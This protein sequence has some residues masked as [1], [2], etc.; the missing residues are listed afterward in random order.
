MSNL[1]DNAGRYG[2]EATPG[3]AVTDSLQAMIA[4]TFK[5]SGGSGPK[6]TASGGVHADQ[7]PR[8]NVAEYA[9]ATLSLASPSLYNHLAPFRAAICGQPSTYSSGL[10]STYAAGFSTAASDITAVATGNQLEKGAGT[11][12]AFPTLAV[13]QVTGFAGGAG[14]NPASFAALVKVAPGSS[15]NLQFLWPTLVDETPLGSVTVEY[16]SHLRMG[17]TLQTF[18]FEIFNPVVSYGNQYST[19]GVKTWTHTMDIKTAEIAESFD[20]VCGA[21]PVPITVAAT[22]TTT[23]APGVFIHNSNVHFGDKTH[24]SYGGM[25]RYNGT[26]L[27]PGSASGQI[28]INK[29]E[30]KMT[31][32]V[33]SSGGLGNFGPLALYTDGMVE[34]MLTIEAMRDS[35]A[36]EQMLQDRENKDFVANIGY[37]MIDGNGKRLYRYYPA[38]QYDTGDSTVGVAQTGEDTISFPMKAK[39]DLVSGTMF[40]ETLLG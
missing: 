33:A 30:H 11:W 14:K 35:A 28:R 34:L 8:D 23:P 15:A 24:P 36:A 39:L 10:I 6:R 16:L 40:Q 12:A 18:F 26:M 21:T 2:P 9:E 17:S 5:P 1:K 4:T 38:L 13:V 22:N 19:V 27:S 7:M 25:F 29:I 31:R 3:A 32:N 20:F 37:C